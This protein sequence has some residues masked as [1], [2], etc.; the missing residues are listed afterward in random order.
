MKEK[1]PIEKA[2]YTKLNFTDLIGLDRKKLLDLHECSWKETN[3]INP[4]F[5]LTKHH[6]SLEKYNSNKKF[7][8]IYFDAFSP[9]KQPELWHQDIF[10][11]MYNLLKDNGFLVT[12]CAKGSVKRTMQRAGF[13]VITLDGPPGKRQMTKGEKVQLKNCL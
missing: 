13:N 5:Q 6:I 10:Q 2:H 8:I 4:Y 9:N 1:N 3:K 11:K 12:Y 7:N